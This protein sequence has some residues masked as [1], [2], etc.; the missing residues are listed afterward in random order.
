MPEIPAI[1]LYGAAGKMGREILSLAARYPSFVVRYGFDKT[2]LGERIG[3]VTIDVEPTSLSED[4]RLVLD[5]SAASAVLDHLET[6]LNRRA[7]YL[8]GVTGLESAIVQ[9]LRASA[10]EIPVLHSPNLSPGMN[11]M[12]TLAAEVARTFPEYARHIVEVHHT[13]KKDSP[14]GTALRLA[15]AVYDAVQEDT[16]ISAMRMGDV[17]GEHTIIF[18]GPGERL[19]ITHHADSRAVFASGALRAADWL[20][21]KSAGFYTMADVLHE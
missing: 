19:E 17:T 1:A 14:S 15:D 11:L 5:F 4:V 16:P 9:E 6:A 20:L 12:F 10:N 13:R 7:G 21:R 18:G 2:A 8:C 3:P